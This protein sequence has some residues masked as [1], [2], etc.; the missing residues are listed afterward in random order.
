MLGLSRSPSP[1][2]SPLKLLQPLRQAFN[3]KF[4]PA[5]ITTAA[6]AA[7]AGHA[8]GSTPLYKNPHASVDARVEDLLGRMTVQEKMA[9]LIQGDMGNYLDLTTAAFN[10]SG[11]VWN[12]DYRA[13]SVWT[14]Y[15]TNMTTVKKAAEL[16]QNYLMHDT[17]LG[18]KP[19]PYTTPQ[20]QYKT[21]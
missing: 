4:G 12:M 11:L 2:P 6:L 7:A 15:Y 21:P 3:M 1:C 17:R 9:Q 10:K 16:A 5:F 8:H 13:N 18:K 19:S 20:Q 14:G